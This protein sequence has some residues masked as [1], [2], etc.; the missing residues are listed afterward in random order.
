MDNIS[1]GLLSGGYFNCTPEWNAD[2][3]GR[4]T[5]YKIYFP[6]EGEASVNLDGKW[7]ELKAGNAYFING[8]MLKSNQ[9]ENNMKVYWLHFIP[10]SHL[11]SMYLNRLEPIHC[12]HKENQILSAIKFDEIT[13]LFQKSDDFDGKLLTSTS[14]SLACYINSIILSLLA[15]MTK[16]NIANIDGV[17][18]DQFMKLE[19]ALQYINLNYCSK[20]KLSD[21]AK[22]SF[23]SSEHFLR[24]FKK[25]MN[26]TPNRYLIMK[27]LNEACILLTKTDMSIQDISE[28]VGFCNQFYFSN[29]F[30]LHFR[31]TPFEYRNTKLSP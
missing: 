2:P 7:Y 6:T 12:W 30:K 22:R 14:L 8:F 26:M 11:V 17:S 16:N 28:A 29:V 1:I 20:I 25:C 5:C 24:L 31:K 19:P 27:R 13:K 15:D 3:N 10:E 23:L 18:E 21:M 9:C 4:D